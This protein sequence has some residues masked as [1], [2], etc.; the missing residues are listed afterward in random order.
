M[1]EHYTAFLAQ[2]PNHPA[3]DTAI[4][5]ALMRELGHAWRNSNHK[6]HKRF[7]AT[8]TSGAARVTSTRP[9]RKD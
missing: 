4:G 6:I 1:R 8:P 9:N 5:A 7:S 3:P 2:K